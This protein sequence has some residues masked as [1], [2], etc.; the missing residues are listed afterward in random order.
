MD[1]ADVH[2][3]DV[4]EGTPGPDW[5][6]P[7]RMTFNHFARYAGS[8]G[9]FHPIHHDRAYAQAAGY[10]D[11]F[12][13]GMFTAGVLAHYASDW[14]GHASVRRFGVRFKRQVF[15]GDTLTC[16]GTITRKYA[17]GDD[18]LVDADL[19]VRNQD[20]AALIEAFATAALPTSAPTPAV[21][22]EA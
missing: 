15:L 3:D 9:S 13:P 7:E 5:T 20:G 10:P 11:V 1:R 17:A 14:F 21:H 16:Q 8:S 2:Y 6:V 4:N 18:Y 12:G 19:W 22:Q